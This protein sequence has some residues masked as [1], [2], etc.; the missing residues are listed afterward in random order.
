MSSSNEFNTSYNGYGKEIHI[1]FADMPNSCKLSDSS[2]M[3]K[4]IQLGL[5]CGMPTDEAYIKALYRTVADSGIAQFHSECV[6]RSRWSAVS[7]KEL[8]EAY[9]EFCAAIQYP[10]KSHEDF[11]KSFIIKMMPK[12]LGDYD[13]FFMNISLIKPDADTISAITSWVS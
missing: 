3:V 12:Q 1:T 9:M 7:G 8:Y 11:M 10:V 6:V 4:L 13:V 5:R 2:Y